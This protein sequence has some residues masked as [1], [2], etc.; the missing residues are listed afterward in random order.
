MRENYDVYS[1]IEKYSSTY[2]NGM[3]GISLSSIKTSL[4]LEEIPPHLQPEYTQKILTFLSTGIRRSQEK[5]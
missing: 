3:G 5:T 2:N 4:D 1:L